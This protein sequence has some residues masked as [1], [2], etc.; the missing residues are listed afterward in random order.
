MHQKHTCNVFFQKDFL[1]FFHASLSAWTV[2]LCG[3]C[4]DK[5]TRD[6]C[7]GNMAAI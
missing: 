1:S 4:G 6:K 3:R 2:P 7:W 5:Y